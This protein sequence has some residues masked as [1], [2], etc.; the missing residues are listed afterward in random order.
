MLYERNIMAPKIKTTKDEL[1]AAALNLVRWEG[2]EA[3]NARNLAAS[4]GCSTQ[5]IFSNFSNMKE[6]TDAVAEAAYGKYL[7]FIKSEIESSRY[8]EYKASGMAYIRFA[9]EERELFKLIF[10][11]DRSGEEPKP[12]PDFEASISLIAAANG[13]SKEKATLLHL[14]MWSVVHGIATMLATSFLML[15]EE[16]ISTML[17]DVYQGTRK[18]HTHSEE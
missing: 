16:L 14:E 18:I 1:I 11:A 5:P 13:I 8:P 17:T 15:D 12:T 10:M 6:L 3:L 9:R 4:I 2:K 7:E